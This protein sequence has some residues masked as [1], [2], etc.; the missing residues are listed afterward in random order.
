MFNVE[1]SD[2]T[3]LPP[4]DRGS[5]SVPYLLDVQ[6]LEVRASV[7]FADDTSPLTG[8]SFHIAAGEIVGL[9]GES[10]AGKTTLA[11]ALLRLLPSPFRVTGGSIRFEARQL[12]S[13][14]ERELRTTRGAR[15]SII[16]QDPTVLNP[17]M[18]VGDQIVEV[19]RAHRDWNNRRSREEAKLLLKEVDIEDVERVHMSYP[20]QLSGGQRQRVVIA[21]ALACRPVLVIADE[22]TSSL[23]PATASS[24]VELLGRLNRQFK[25][26]FLLISHD[27]KVLK[28]LADR[29]IVMYAGRIIEQGRR[30]AV[31]CDPLHPYTRAL[32]SCSLPEESAVRPLAAKS[33]VPS[34]AGVTAEQSRAQFHCAFESRCVDRMH[35]CAIDVP[36]EFEAADA[37]TVCCFKFGNA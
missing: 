3:L 12:L 10:G 36:K 30:E 13:L 19:L 27:I 6:D 25:V 34:I 15:M 21:Q 29:V 17:V 14:S 23:D 37:H 35:I 9:L 7:D 4:L 26:A 32:L 28:Q 22:P 2:T 5:S 24:I 16:Y 18:R 1:L 33:P 31:L 8:I 20:H 11:M